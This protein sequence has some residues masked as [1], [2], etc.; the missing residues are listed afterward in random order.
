MGTERVKN[1]RYAHGRALAYSQGP[2]PL[3]TT[4]ESVLETVVTEQRTGLRN[5]MFAAVHCVT[6]AGSWRRDQHF[7]LSVGR[8]GTPHHPGHAGNHDWST[9]PIQRLYTA[10]YLC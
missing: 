8:T 10:A 6:S 4:A 1:F 2:V 7:D 9:I 3:Q 5:A